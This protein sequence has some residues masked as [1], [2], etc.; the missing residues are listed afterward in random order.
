[1]E[2]AQSLVR[3]CVRSFY[4]TKHILVIDALILHSAL[5]DDDMAYLMGMNTKELHKLC[6]RLKEDR[7]LAVH[8]RAEVKE[9]QQRP[10]NRTYY[11]IDYRATIDAIKWRVYL[12]NKKVQGNTVPEAERKEWFCSRCKS[13]WTQIEVL[14]KWLPESGFLCHKCGNVLIHDVEN[15][16]GGHEQSTKYHAQFRFITDMLPKLDEVIVPENNF[17]RA[18]ASQLKVIRDETNPANETAPVDAAAA[19]PTAVRGMANVGPTSISVTLTASEGP[20]EADIAAEQARK[21]KIASQNAMPVHF[22][23]STITGEQ[24]KFAQSSHQPSQSLE[25]DKKSVGADT[26]LMN[27]DGAE[28]D[29]YFARLKAEQQKEAEREKDEEY[30]TDDEEDEEDF[31]DVVPTGTGSGIGT[32]ASSAGDSKPNLVSLANGLPGVLKKGGSASASGT[33]TGATSPV[34]GPG[35]PNDEGRPTKRVRI[36][37][38]VPKE[39]ESEEDMEFE[40]V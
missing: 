17:D 32:P 22:S 33:S 2:L 18:F 28:I 38:P 40:D 12:M 23:H 27:G 20:T 30:E 25:H 1:M 15:N 21:E 10:M 9:G 6:G 16:R 5:R 35:T 29:D 7:F 11:F 13:E 26:P 39:E 36:E 37:E 31:E 19:K 34:T 8:T 3:S 14:D 4:E 24:V